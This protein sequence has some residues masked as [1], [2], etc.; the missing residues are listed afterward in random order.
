MGINVAYFIGV[1]FGVAE[2]LIAQYLIKDYRKRQKQYES[3]VKENADFPAAE[4]KET[5]TFFD[6]EIL[7]SWESEN[8]RD[9][10]DERAAYYYKRSM[11]KFAE[12][13]HK[14]KS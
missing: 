10:Q 12:Y 2:V 8:S 1:F 3:D 13:Y 9:N 14:A 5:P 7:K 11:L 4:K 6:E